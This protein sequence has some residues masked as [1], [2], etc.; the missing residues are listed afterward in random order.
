MQESLFIISLDFELMWGVRDKRTIETYGNNIRGVRQVIPSLLELFEKYQVRASF[1]TVGFLFARNKQ[2]L[3]SFQPEDK[4]SYSLSKYSPYEN[5]YFSSIGQSEQD[6]IYHF[7]ESL[8]KLI[9][10]Y[11]H[12][13]I[14]SHTFSHY[15]CLENA[16][17]A[18]FEQDLLAAKA[19]AATYGIELKSIVFPRNQYTPGH[20]DIC[21]KLD[22]ISYRGNPSSVLYEP[23]K[24]EEQSKFVR[25]GRLADT[26]INL[27]GHK[28]FVPQNEEGIVNIPASSFLRPFSSKLKWA[29]ASRLRRIK[30]SMTHAAKNKEA[31]HLWWHPH[32]FGVNLQENLAFLEEILKHFQLLHKEY[33]MESKT[34]RSIAEEILQ[35]HAV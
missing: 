1:A 21:K 9:Q 30:N 6:D 10:Q 20:I 5:N 17:L 27:T 12:Q 19:I 28:S 15:Y 23:T 4:P 7:A 33:G 16:S 34:M 18:S 22:F 24:N 29:E 2:E 26:Y 32:N 13:E 11:P 14:A 8:I 31:Y 25:A 3:L 35:A